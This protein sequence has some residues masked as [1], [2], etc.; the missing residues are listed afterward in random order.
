M[1]ISM[2]EQPARETSDDVEIRWCT[3]AAFV[4]Q[5]TELHIRTACLRT[6]AP[7]AT[8]SL[9]SKDYE[10]TC[11]NSKLQIVHTTVQCSC[12][13]HVMPWTATNCIPVKYYVWSTSVDQLKWLDWAVHI[14]NKQKFLL[15]CGELCF[16]V[17]TL[18]GHA[19]LQVG[20][21][22]IALHSM[23]TYVVW[24]RPITKLTLWTKL[25]GF[26]IKSMGSQLCTQYHI[27]Y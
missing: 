8:F 5:N 16:S 18:I 2:F 25:E 12:V 27:R 6:W 1:A 15:I 11:M 13:Y 17:V 26:V 14:K 20:S 21:G 24:C 23:H 3:P 4:Q 22:C 9:D 19:K 10:C 7:G